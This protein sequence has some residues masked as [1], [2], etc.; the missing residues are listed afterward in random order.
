MTTNNSTIASVLERAAPSTDQLRAWLRSA[1]DAYERAVR[2]A[3]TLAERLDTYET[4]RADL[5][6]ERDALR[7]LLR[8]HAPQVTDGDVAL[9]TAAAR[10]A[11]T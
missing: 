5:V 6:A 2:T 11:R 1:D 9:A 10:R 3:G 8:K 4:I 7:M